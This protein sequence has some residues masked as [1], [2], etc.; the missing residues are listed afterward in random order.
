MPTNSRRNLKLPQLTENLSQG[1]DPPPPAIN[2]H[3]I[4][5]VHERVHVRIL[6]WKTHSDQMIHK[7]KANFHQ[8]M[9]G[10]Q[11]KIDAY[12]KG[13]YNKR[14]RQRAV[15]VRTLTHVSWNF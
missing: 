3:Q 7:M 10:R 13:I 1:M 9:S 8:C 12:I 2:A 11:T 6:Q 15:L 14:I 4:D 5:C